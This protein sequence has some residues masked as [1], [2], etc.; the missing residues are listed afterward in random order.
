MT[1][2]GAGELAPTVGFDLEAFSMD[3]PYCQIPHT[4]S[5]LGQNYFIWGYK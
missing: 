4:A 2:L 3:G 5:L 1:P